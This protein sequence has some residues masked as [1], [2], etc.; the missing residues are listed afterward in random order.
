MTRM[1]LSGGLA[2]TLFLSACTSGD[3]V[4]SSPAAAAA[5]QAPKVLVIGVSDPLC[6][7]SACSC[8][9]DS[10]I[11]SY[12]TAA[13]RVKESTGVELRFEYFEDPGQLAEGLAAGRYDGLVC[14]AWSGMTLA[15][16]TGRP[17]RRVATVGMPAGEPEGLCGVAMVLKDSPAKS[18][19]DLKGRRLA[20]GEPKDYDKSW[21]VGAAL[22]KAGVADCKTHACGSCSTAVVDLME[23]RADAAFISSYAVRYS[24][25]A[26]LADPDDFREIGRTETIPFVSVFLDSAKV[27]EAVR[28][29]VASALLELSGDAAPADLFSRGF[30]A[31]EPWAPVELE[32]MP[33]AA[34]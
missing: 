15:R 22:A 23:G 10:A 14:K 19:A 29:S 8:V 12:A 32:R 33:S 4:A 18:I 9:G 24:C 16:R 11:R 27:P 30:A 17:L 3:G 26:D 20:I 1:F 6:K 25:L 13:A 5:G 2:A 28:D 31:P 34:R 21:A 7:L